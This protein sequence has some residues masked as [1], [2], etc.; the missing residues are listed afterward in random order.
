VL[1]GIFLL[2][3]FLIEQLLAFQLG[4]LSEII[5]HITF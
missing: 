2:L 4:Y 3:G 5:D 1:C